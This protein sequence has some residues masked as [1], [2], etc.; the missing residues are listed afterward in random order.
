MK[1]NKVNT[2]VNLYKRSDSRPGKP[3]VY[4]S[5]RGDIILKDG[6]DLNAPSGKN[7]L[8]FSQLNIENDTIANIW[9][10]TYI[11]DPQQIGRGD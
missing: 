8:Y 1:V 10:I 9:C 7:P 4:I 6:W 5:N 11:S 2:Y 3:L